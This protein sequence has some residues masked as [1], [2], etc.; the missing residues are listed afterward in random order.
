MEITRPEPAHVPCCWW[1]CPALL[2]PCDQKT[3]PFVLDVN[4][5]PCPFSHPTLDCTPHPH[6]SSPSQHSL[7]VLLL[8]IPA[9][10]ANDL[11]VLRQTNTQTYYADTYGRNHPTCPIRPQWPIVYQQDWRG[12]SCTPP[13]TCLIPCQSRQDKAMDHPFRVE[14]L[15]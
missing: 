14:I 7:L 4:R 6:F 11:D 1:H 10:T 13:Q 12:G 2:G 8:V 15:G 9:D 3:A 5:N